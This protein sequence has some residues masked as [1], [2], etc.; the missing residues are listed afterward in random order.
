MSAEDLATVRK[1]IEAYNAGDVEGVLATM[2]PDIRFVP[3]RSLLEGGEYRG[4]AGIRK[5]MAD[6]DDDWSERG[7]DISELRDTE[8]TV[9]VLGEF[10][11][12]GRASNTEVRF[13][14]AWLCRFRDGKMLGMRAFTDLDQA[15]RELSLAV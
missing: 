2:D 5:Y 14:I 6:M 8:N 1:G 15:L 9:L 7:I 3:V 4:H 12:T 11:G 13:P 10:H